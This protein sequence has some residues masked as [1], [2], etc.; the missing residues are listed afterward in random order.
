VDEGLAEVKKIN[1]QD[2][3][4]SDSL[5]LFALTYKQLNNL[6]M[7][8]T[9]RENLAKLDPWN[10]PNYLEL[11]R[12]YKAVGNLVKSQEMLDKILSF[13]P[14]GPIAEQASKELAS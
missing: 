4:S 3:R 14:N 6:P 5:M 9:Y 13:A 11:G 12:D 7:V 10:A 2:P 1:L 8:I